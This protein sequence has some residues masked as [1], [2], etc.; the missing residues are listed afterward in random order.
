MTQFC[1]VADLESFLQVTIPEGLVAS[2]ERAITAAS[3]AIQ[4]YCGQTLTAVEDD[5]V[6]LD[7]VGGSRLIL[8]ELPVTAVSAVVEDDEELDEDDDYKL[9]QHGIL[10]RIGRSWATGI[11]IVTVTYDHGYATLP[12]DVVDVCVRAAARAYQAGLRASAMEAVPGVSAESLGDHSVT[13]APE[14]GAGETMMGASAAPILLRSEKEAL[15]A[16]RV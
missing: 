7:V 9:G 1:T 3:A 8:P 6:T 15:E 14:S 4:R 12:D 11:Q 5:E 10:H 13:Y 2:A 16:F